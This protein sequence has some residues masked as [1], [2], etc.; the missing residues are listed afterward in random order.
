MVSM[1][2]IIGEDF[3][4]ITMAQNRVG[5]ASFSIE[6]T[7]KYARVGTLPGGAIF[8]IVL[9][10]IVVIV[11]YVLSILHASKKINL[12]EI[13]YKYHGRFKELCKKKESAFEYSM[14]M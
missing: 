3:R 13:F 1:T 4:V 11:S 12:K 2:E 5:K 14:R 7:I 9:L 8:G 6:L 10:F